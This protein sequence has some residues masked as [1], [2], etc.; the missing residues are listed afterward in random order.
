VEIE[1]TVEVVGK[2][3]EV[4]VFVTVEVGGLDVTVAVCV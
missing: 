4:T 1:V 2:D 3:E